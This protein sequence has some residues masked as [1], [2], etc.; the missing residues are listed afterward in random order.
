ML[1][2]GFR[3]WLAILALLAGVIGAAAPA[4]SDCCPAAGPTSAAAEAD[5]ADDCCPT[6][7]PRPEPQPAE[8]DRGGCDCPR[9]C[10]FAPAPVAELRAAAPIQWRDARVGM[11]PLAVTRARSADYHLDLM[12]PPRA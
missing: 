7:R 2:H 6:S 4:I 3:V 12:R 1:G 9:P 11:V 10:C 5:H 8:N